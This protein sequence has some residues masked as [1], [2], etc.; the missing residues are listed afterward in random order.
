MF[1]FE[2]TRNRRKCNLWWNVFNLF[3]E[4]ILSKRHSWKGLR[5]ILYFI[6]KIK[7]HVTRP[8]NCVSFSFVSMS[9]RTWIWVYKY[10]S[11]GMWLRACCCWHVYVPY[12]NFRNIIT[13]DSE[14]NGIHFRYKITDT[15]KIDISCVRVQ[16]NTYT[17]D[18]W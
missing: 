12:I 5:T 3:I 14:W 8:E 17:V 16:L 15:E 7:V 4:W 13:C 2:C 1:H 11:I 10:R 6:D 18:N 9:V